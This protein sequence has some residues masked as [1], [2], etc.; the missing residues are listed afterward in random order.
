MKTFSELSVRRVIGHAIIEDSH[1]DEIAR[2]PNW[3]CGTPQAD[4]SVE[5][6]AEI[7]RAC[8]CHDELVQLVQDFGAWLEL[9]LSMGQINRGTANRD[10]DFVSQIR[11]AIAK[12]TGE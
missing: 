2:I 7:V 9:G 4:G 1:G 6:A 12:A 10:S 3:T 5:R 11:A 8:N